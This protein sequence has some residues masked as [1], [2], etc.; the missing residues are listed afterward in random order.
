MCSVLTYLYTAVIGVSFLSSLIRSRLDMPFHLKLFSLLLGLTFFVE[1]TAVWMMKTHH[2]NVG[3][4][5][6][7]MLIEFWVYGY[8]YYQIIHVRRI[9]NI[10]QGYLWIFPIFWTIVVFGIFGWK[11]WN[12]YVVIAGSLCV[13]SFSVVYY[14][15]L[16]AAPDPIPLGRLPEFWIATGLILFYSC[17]L[18]YMGMLNFLVNN[19]LVLA[20]KLLTV[21]RILIIIMY[22][23][24]TYAFLCRINTKRS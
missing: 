9:K 13:I 1:C 21:L 15:Q 7:F 17:N 23:L 12:S 16:F 20:E 22:S 18:P 4:Y 10:I 2:S 19:Y 14:Y 6:S 11:N 8:Y 24:F 3:L 5:N